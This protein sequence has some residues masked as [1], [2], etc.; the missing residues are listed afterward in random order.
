MERS[1]EDDEVAFGRSAAWACK[2]VSKYKV[3]DGRT[4]YELMTG[5]KF[6]H[7]AYSFGQ[8]IWGMWLADTNIKNG[9][10]SK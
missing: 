1:D 7:A 6:K 8:R 4:A 5:H 9:H 3:R 2:V 10:D